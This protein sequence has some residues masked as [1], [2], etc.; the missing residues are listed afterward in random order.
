MS[1]NPSHLSN[2]SLAQ[3]LHTN[4]HSIE[5]M[6]SFVAWKSSDPLK[7]QFFIFFI[8]LVKSYFP[9]FFRRQIFLPFPISRATAPI[10][11][12]ILEMWWSLRIF[13]NLC[14]MQR[15][16]LPPKLSLPLPMQSRVDHSS[17][18]QPPKSFLLLRIV[19]VWGFKVNCWQHQVRLKICKTN[20]EKH[21]TIFKKLSFLVFC[22]IHWI[23][24][25]QMGYLGRAPTN[26]VSG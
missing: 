24:Q 18:T 5:N 6:K 16:F 2:K 22:W 26:C 25:N 8:Q 15:F 7:L 3:I 1:P 17:Q 13:F 21:R 12:R 9:L 11:W 10:G 14:A 20:K 4:P 23:E 19:R